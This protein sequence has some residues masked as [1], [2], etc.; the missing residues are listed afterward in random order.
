MQPGTLHN[1]PRMLSILQ[2]NQMCLKQ[3]Q[4]FKIWLKNADRSTLHQT[5][6]KMRNVN[7]NRLV[8]ISFAVFEE[9]HLCISIHTDIIT[10]R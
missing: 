6:W 1:T 4:F 3:T 5:K 9:G 10:R 8:F 7:I 2:N